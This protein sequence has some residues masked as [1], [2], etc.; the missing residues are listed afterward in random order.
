MTKILQIF[1]FVTCF[2]TLYDLFRATELRDLHERLRNVVH[3]A[4]HPSHSPL[5]AYTARNMNDHSLA[6]PRSFRSIG[7]HK[8]VQTRL[9]S[10]QRYA[11]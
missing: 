8:K 1:T 7:S 4:R 5:T 10:I 11:E 9:S 2:H 6:W 3:F